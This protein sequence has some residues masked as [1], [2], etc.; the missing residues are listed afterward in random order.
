M[1]SLLTRSLLVSVIF[2]F[3]GCA[4]SGRQQ[5]GK[6]IL[7][8][9]VLPV[10]EFIS[11]L[12][13]D[14]FIIN[15]MV[16]EGMPPSVYEP[17]AEQ[18]KSLGKTKLYFSLEA[19]G[20]ELTILRNISSD[21]PEMKIINIT[22][23]IT[24]ISGGHKHGNKQGIDPHMWMSPKQSVILI[25]NIYAALLKYYP[26]NKE[27]FSANFMQIMKKMEEVDQYVQNA[28]EPVKGN[29]FLI[30]H[31]AL[32]Y[33][34]RDYDLVQIPIE[35]QG[36]EP[37]PDYLNALIGQAKQ[38]QIQLMFIQRQFDVS[39]AHIVA[40]ETGSRVI[41][42]DPLSSAWSETIHQVTDAFKN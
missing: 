26:E 25:K 7:T 10:A 12:T 32:S 22:Q 16:P 4:G 13:G 19:L 28:I 17:T 36:K 42:F 11:E 33:Y 2:F 18:L 34:A 14:D 27:E 24:P 35:I 3:T 20:F 21:Y 1:K 41:V 6:H 38:N 15:T 9:T 23:G 8:T 5:S 29:S 39:F 37:S 40:E 31:P 30:Y